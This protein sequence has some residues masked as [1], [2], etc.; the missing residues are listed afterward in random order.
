MQPTD[1][2][3][4]VVGDHDLDRS[5]LAAFLTSAIGGLA[6]EMELL[7]FHGGHSNLTYLATFGARELVVKRAPLGGTP[8]AH[9]MGRE[10]TI[11]SRLHGRYPYAPRALAFCDDPGVAGSPF[12]VMERAHGVIV[13]DAY[14]PEVRG[15][16]IARQFTHVIDALAE[17]HA[18]DVAAAGLGD[19]GRPLGYRRRQLDGWSKRLEAARTENMEDFTDVIAWLGANLPPEPELPAVVHND[20]KLDNLLWD[21]ADLTRLKAVLDWEMATVGDGLLDL[22][23]TLSFWVQAG[24]PPELLALRAMPSAH[25]QAPTRREALERYAARTGRRLPPAAFLFAF[26]LFRRAVIEQ[27]KYRRYQSGASTDPRFAGLD[28]AVGTLH[29]LCRQAIAGELAT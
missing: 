16:E 3:A 5:R 23:C 4:A 15:E 24:D 8:G 9:D 2:P 21:A 14:P 13:R 18:V 28:A 27:Q 19:F 12:C 25:P 22:A 26:G 6:G 11:L 1:A 29:G 20:F 10:F 7:Q 17:L